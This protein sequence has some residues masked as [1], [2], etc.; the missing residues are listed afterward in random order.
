M[1]NQDLT[2]IYNKY[3]NLVYRI[4]LT[5]T[6]NEMDAEDI[7]QDVFVKRLYYRKQFKSEEHEKNWMIRVTINKSKDHLKSFWKKNRCN[8]DDL[9][10]Q[11]IWNIDYE[12]K[13]LLEELFRLAD[14]YRITLY[15]HYF[16]GYNCKEIAQLLHCGESAVKMR[17]KKG[18]E[19]LKQKL[20]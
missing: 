8:I 20:N 10:Q 3:N 14:K 13:Q 2:Q 5:Y 7:M 16:E 17:L 18:R 1:Q 19:L 9:Q 6:K 11:A 12:K 4:A 15:L